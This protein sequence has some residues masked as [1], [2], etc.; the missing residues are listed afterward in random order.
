MRNA[1]S[2]GHYHHAQYDVACIYAVLGQTDSAV[3][4]LTNAAQNGF[5]CYPFF[6]QDRL[7]KPLRGDTRFTSLMQ[8]L[9]E[10]CSTY[11]RLYDI[12][13]SSSNV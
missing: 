11:R 3:E 6:E 10:E 7:L 2:Y 5:P 8:K 9:R 12:L 4:W 1:K 13:Q